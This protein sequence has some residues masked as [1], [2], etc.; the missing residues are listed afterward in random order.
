MGERDGDFY[1]GDSMAIDCIGNI[2]GQ[3]SGR[4]GVLICEL[5]DRAWRLREKFATAKDRRE[6]FYSSYYYG[7]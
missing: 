5:E 7:G 1:S 4:E 3:I 2:L 6:E